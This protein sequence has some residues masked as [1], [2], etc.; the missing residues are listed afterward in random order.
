MLDFS[1][2]GADEPEAA[3]RSQLAWT[4]AQIAVVWVAADLGY[5]FLLPAL[6]VNP[7]YNAGSVAIAIYYA[8]WVGIAVITFWPLYATWSRYGRWATFENRYTSYIVWSVFFAGFVAFA[9]YVLPLL[10][11]TT[12]T[13]SFSPPEVRVAT[14]WYFL[15]KSIEILFQQLLVVALVLAL[16][17][18]QF[19]LRRIS[20]YCGLIF[21]AAHVLLVFGDTPTGYVIRFMIAATAFGFAFPYLILKVRNGFAYSYVVHWLYYA[22]TVAMPHF[23]ANGAFYLLFSAPAK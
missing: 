7:S 13:E 23:F 14:E 3:E 20:L 22:V 12:W 21:G 5:Y 8:F 16:S 10:P 1:S 11:P 6:G 4:V 18:Q 15:P 19:P 17:V 9:V 2:N